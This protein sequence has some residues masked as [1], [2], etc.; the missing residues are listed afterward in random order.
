MIFGAILVLCTICAQSKIGEK[1][2]R[3]MESKVYTEME[4]SL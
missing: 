2:T 4:E 1:I 3:I